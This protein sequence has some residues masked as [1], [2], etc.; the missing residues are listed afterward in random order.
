MEQVFPKVR[1]MSNM[2]LK[3]WSDYNGTAG[4]GP[5]LTVQ[6]QKEEADINNIVKS[7]G[8][9]GKLPVGVRIPTYGDFEGVSD[10]REAVEA[11]KLA[12]ESFMAM[13]SD[14][15]KRL[16]HDPQKF[17]EWCIDPANLEEARKYGLAP[18]PP[19]TETPKES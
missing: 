7:F 3:E 1:T 19:V 15:R 17:I 18:I 9:T 11:M 12:E 4:V 14:L 10:Y 8:V 5:S 2:D 6:S 16:D 13:P